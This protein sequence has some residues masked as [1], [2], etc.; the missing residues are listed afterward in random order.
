MIPHFAC[1]LVNLGIIYHPLG[2]SNSFFL[3]FT[4]FMLIVLVY[5]ADVA[6]FLH[7]LVAEIVCG[8]GV[9]SSSQ[10]PDTLLCVLIDDTKGSVGGDQR[11]EPSCPGQIIGNGV[12]K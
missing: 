12:L 1:E 7:L 9:L 10:R 5:K 6:Q 4:G 3:F 2:F 11:E 8:L